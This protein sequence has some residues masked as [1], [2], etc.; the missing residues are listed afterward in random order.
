V[1]F[2]SKAKKLINV[3]AVSRSWSPKAS[4]QVKLRTQSSF[5]ATTA[6]VYWWLWPFRKLLVT[7]GKSTSPSQAGPACLVS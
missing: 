2:I 3:R 5:R 6:N 1:E 7:T 4:V